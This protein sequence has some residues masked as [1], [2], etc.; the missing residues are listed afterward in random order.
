MIDLCI[1]LV[2]YKVT[3]AKAALSARHE[4]MPIIEK[5]ISFHHYKTTDQK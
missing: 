3:N 4:V 5:I 1:E 2:V